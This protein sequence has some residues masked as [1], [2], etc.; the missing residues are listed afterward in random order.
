MNFLISPNA[1][2]G[3]IPADEAAEIMGDV[4][5][6]QIPDTQITLQPIADGGDGTCGLLIHSLGLEKVT[7]MSLDPIGR[8]IRSTFGWDERSQKAY[9]D[10]STASGIGVL[11]DTQKQV[12]LTSTF[13]TGLIIQKAIAQGAK[14]IILGLGGSA[15]VDLGLGVL[16]SFGFVFLDQNGRE[17]LPFSPNFISQ[18]HHIQRPVRL[19]KVKFTFLCDVKNYFFGTD[20]AV[21][22]FGPQK[23]LKPNQLSEFERQCGRIV[24]LLLRKVHR[25][26]SDQEGFGAAGGIALGLSLFFPFEIRFGAPYFFRLVDLESKVEK[27][28]WILT[29]EGRYDSQ[30]N[31][32]KAC[33]E[34]LQAARKSGKK[35]ALITSGKEADGAGFDEVYRLPELNFSEAGFTEKA[36]ENLLRL[37]MDFTAKRISDQTRL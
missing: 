22:V 28:D 35:I 7:F 14:E 19:P 24:D 21:P 33:F 32:G 29:G 18:I 5:R 23:G 16:Q 8:P 27:A 10:V 9:L 31:Q 34:L 2:K 3:T 20:G 25:Q 15:T 26:W 4:I 36:R 37:C 30:S 17:I 13:G 1:F 12:D 6:K 11:D